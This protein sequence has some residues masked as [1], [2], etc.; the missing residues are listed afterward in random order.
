MSSRACT[1]NGLYHPL[2]RYILR[3]YKPDLAMV[4]YPMTDEFQH[5][6]LG[7]VSPTL[8]GGA[9]NPAY[10]DVQVNGTPDGRVKEREAFLRR[11]YCGADATL[12]LVQSA[13]AAE[14]QHL[15]L[16]RPR[17]CAAVPGHRRLQ[18][19]GGPGPALQAADL[20]LPPGDR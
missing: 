13:D 5:Q 19:A 9:P 1:G 16:V 6:F 3:S 14:G 7:L 4:G 11:A 12:G 10:D 2:I 20:Q 15:C 17:L 8:P 18:G